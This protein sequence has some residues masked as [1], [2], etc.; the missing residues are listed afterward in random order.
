M[1]LLPQMSDDLAVTESVAGLLV[2]VYAV[3]VAALS[4]PLVLATR[5]LPR[6]GLLLGTLVAY[7]LSNALVAVAPSFGVVAGARAL[8][9]IAHAIFF[10]VAIGYAS[11]LVSP[12]FTAAHSPWSPQARLRGS[13]S[14]SPCRPRSAR[15]SAGGPR[16][17]C[18]AERAR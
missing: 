5:R 2:T 9:G 16:S 6:K 11:R 17:L 13:C 10:S 3:M 7:T 15:L 1:G 8:G 12:Q 4:V 14:A 18:W